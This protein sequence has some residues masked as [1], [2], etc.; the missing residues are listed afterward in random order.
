MPGTNNRGFL[1]EE[2]DEDLEQVSEWHHCPFFSSAPS[3]FLSTHFG[4]K[5]LD[6][7]LRNYLDLQKYGVKVYIY[8]S[9]Y[10]WFRVKGLY[11]T[12]PNILIS[13][14][15]PLQCFVVFCFQDI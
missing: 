7:K 9:I 6:Q 1:T 14:L 3:E 8:I 5:D 12:S 11:P 13:T 2:R 4:E 10:K 15:G